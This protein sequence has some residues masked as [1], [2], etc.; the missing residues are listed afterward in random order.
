MKYTDFVTIKNQK[1]LI[2]HHHEKYRKEI[3][4]T[5]KQL[6]NIFPQDPPGSKYHS[7]RL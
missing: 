2:L 5:I 4:S 3:V 7:G 6:Q 1:K